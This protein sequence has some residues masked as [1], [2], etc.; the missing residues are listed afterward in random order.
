MESKTSSGNN[1]NDDWVG[2]HDAQYLHR[3]DTTQHIDSG[4]A[5]LEMG[6]GYR[7]EALEATAASEMARLARLSKHRLVEGVGH[8]MAALT[9]PGLPERHQSL[10]RFEII[11]YMDVGEEM[12]ELAREAQQSELGADGTEAEEY[13]ADAVY[14][15]RTPRI[16][17]IVA[18]EKKYL[19][20][21]ETLIKVYVQ[22]L[23]EDRQ[24]LFHSRI[25]SEEEFHEMF[26][27]VEQL[28]PLHETFLEKLTARLKLRDSSNDITIGDV[29]IKF[30][31]FFKIYH[32]YCNTFEASSK[33]VG[34]L[35]SERSSFA[36][37][38]AKASKDPRTLHQSLQSLMI[39]PVQRI[40]RYQLL[41]EA[42]L[43]QTP[44][45]HPDHVLLAEAERQMKST[46]G[47]I[48]ATI[49]QH[50]DSARLFDMAYS[51]VP[52]QRMLVAAHRR[53]I[54]KGPLR[55]WNNARATE[56]QQLYG[57]LF[58]DLI[59][60]GEEAG[61]GQYKY[62]RQLTLQSVEDL[63]DDTLRTN[64]F[65]VHGT[66]GQV[67]KTLLLSTATNADKSRWVEALY[68][69]SEQ[70]VARVRSMSVALD[71]KHQSV[72]SR[73][74][75][76][77]MPPS[78]AP[79]F[80]HSASTDSPGRR[81]ATDP[82]QHLTRSFSAGNGG[83]SAFSARGGGAGA[84]AQAT[85]GHALP[86][87]F[88][89]DEVLDFD[90][91]DEE[92]GDGACYLAGFGDETDFAQLGVGD[93]DATS[94]TNVDGGVVSALAA[95]ELDLTARLRALS[96]VKESPEEGD[97]DAGNDGGAGGDD[98]GDA[99]GSG[100]N[101]PAALPPRPMQQA[102]GKDDEPPPLP[103]RPT[104]DSNVS[105]G[106]PP[107]LPARPAATSVDSAASE[108]PPPLPSRPSID[109][110]DATGEGG[111]KDGGGEDA[112]RLVCT[113]TADF[114]SEDGGLAVVLGDQVTLLDETL[115]GEFANI[116][117]ALG[118][119]GRVPAHC[120]RVHL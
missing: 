67:K 75:R 18:T 116:Q 90:V 112:P 32:P 68:K 48:D 43:K 109:D 47:D 20:H 13:D 97:G 80:E 99:D 103:A 42:V 105:D 119:V 22:P 52:P 25:V 30:A 77:R 40:A 56:P 96:A 37:F 78:G 15:S 9:D 64:A 89:V 76:S 1:S 82:G 57:F 6:K 33:L 100:G 5:C 98:N 49:R 79:I 118:N 59:L 69:C 87:S 94:N 61:A 28:I 86:P 71:R 102:D 83:G 12:N 34:K 81:R 24:T 73:R 88:D 23:R 29:F 106:P 65:C 4:L 39:M 120:I 46:V 95:Q 2:G 84:A 36:K 58:N 104:V 108:P 45:G 115:T 92:G 21:L 17:E 72:M 44:P 70:I 19:Q 85:G 117:D 8:L 53:F 11:R 41:I 3:C 51:F 14:A 55:Y 113:V 7:A 50:Q 74:P 63:A 66:A 31:P 27:S 26:G 16:N 10:L 107:L 91:S 101:M 54:R 111:G 60:L 93:G 38:L 62:V 114:T 110:D 35:L